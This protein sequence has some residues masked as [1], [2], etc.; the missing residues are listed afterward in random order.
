MAGDVIALMRHLGHDRFAVVGHDRGSYVAPRLTLD[1]PGT[2]THLVVADSV[3]IGE[4]LAR[5]DAAFAQSWWHWFFLGG[6]RGLPERVITADPDAWYGLID[7]DRSGSMGEESL[8]DLRDAV[9]A[10]SVVHAMCEDYRAGLGIDRAADDADQA[11][12]HRV[13]CPLLMLWATRDDMVDLYGDP[14]AVWRAW[15]DDVTGHSIDSGHHIAEE[16]PSELAHAL[17]EHLRR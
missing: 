12:G 8:A 6:S 13:T 3:P 11:A 15:A 5:A 17:L 7:P 9:H 4:A 14:L 10:S 2:V 16:V 1:H